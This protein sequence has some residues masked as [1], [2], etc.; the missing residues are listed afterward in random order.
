MHF[1]PNNYNLNVTRK[2]DFRW[3]TLGRKG[4]VLRII[5]TYE[6]RQWN[7]IFLFGSHLRAFGTIIDRAFLKN[8]WIRYIL[9]IF[10]HTVQFQRSTTLPFFKQFFQQKLHNKKFN[11]GLIW[12]I[13][14]SISLVY[15]VWCLFMKGWVDAYRFK[16][17]IQEC[18]RPYITA[19]TSPK[20]CCNPISL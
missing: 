20:H 18:I 5:D 13:F 4:I 12:K 1:F 6:G 7:A 19:W 14:V 16:L 9:E 2:G 17:C 8:K 15:K 11:F 3:V 10:I